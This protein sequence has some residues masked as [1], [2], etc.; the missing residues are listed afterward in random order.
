MPDGKMLFTAG[1]FGLWRWFRALKGV[2]NTLVGHRT[3]SKTVYGLRLK[4]SQCCCTLAEYFAVDEKLSIAISLSFFVAKV[5]G[6][7]F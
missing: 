5:D 4:N 1:F 6:A 3:E 2:S 7:T